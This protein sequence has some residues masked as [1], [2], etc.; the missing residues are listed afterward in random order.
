MKGWG[1]FGADNEKPDDVFQIESV[2]HDWLFPQVSAVC[3]HG[4]AGTFGNNFPRIFLE[5]S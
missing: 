1:G 3:H 4:G 2:P 5:F